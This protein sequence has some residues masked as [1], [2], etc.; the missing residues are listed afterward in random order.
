M[1]H[2]NFKEFL[3]QK[4][5]SQ[6]P[7]V[8]SLTSLAVDLYRW[9]R[10]VFGNLFRRKRKTWARLEGVQR[11]LSNGGPLHLLKLEMRLR[12]ELNLILQEIETLWFQKSRVEALQDGDRNAK[13]FHISTIICRRANRI[14]ALQHDDGHW[15]SSTKEIKHLVVNYFANLFTEA[16]PS[17]RIDLPS[18]LFPRLPEATLTELSKPYSSAEIFRALRSMAPYKAPGL[19][20]FPA[21]FFQR[22]WNLVGPNVCELVLGVLNGRHLPDGLNDTF[23]I[24]LAKVA[25]PHKVN[26]FRPIGLCNVA[27]KLVM[28]VL[29]HRIQKVLPDLI[30]LS[31]S[32][33]VP[34]DR[35]ATISLSCKKPY[36][37]CIKSEAIVVTWQLSLIWRRPTTG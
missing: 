19:D 27:Y 21:L 16:L 29:V 15:I 17:P 30:S 31:Q 26:Q 32:S 20:G 9:N 2:R 1:E 3:H 23:L 18:G 5:Q 33:F 6:Q 7:L 4:W 37:Q 11:C 22:Y 13:Y 10:E 34:A 35:L 8:P 24:L 12:S 25:H 36:I 14:E 28:K